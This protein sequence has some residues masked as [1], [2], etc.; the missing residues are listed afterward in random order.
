[1][2]SDNGFHGDSGGEIM[3]VVGMMM[4]VIM[5]MMK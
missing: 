3:T 2:D 1:M 5:V 4:L